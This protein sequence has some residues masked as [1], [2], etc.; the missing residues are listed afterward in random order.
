MLACVYIS[1]SFSRTT[2]QSII[3]AGQRNAPWQKYD[4]M[5]SRRDMNKIHLPMVS[6]P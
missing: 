3:S 5:C 1:G 4:S 2:L 6:Q